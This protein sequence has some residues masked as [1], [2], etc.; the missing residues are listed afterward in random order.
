MRINA[1]HSEIFFRI[2]PKQA[3]KHVVSHLK[4]IAQKSYRIN[5]IYSTSIQFKLTIRV[6]DNQSSERGNNGGQ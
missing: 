4:K 5:P 3:K 6:N 2:I 1:S